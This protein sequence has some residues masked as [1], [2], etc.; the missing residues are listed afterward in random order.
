MALF[1]LVC[2]VSD[3]FHMFPFFIREVWK[4]IFSIYR[5][6]KQKI[7]NKRVP[8]FS[9]CISFTGMMEGA[10]VHAMNPTTHSR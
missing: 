8:A 1:R 10:A 2:K 7:T 4:Y 5:E 6:F 3:L 9:W